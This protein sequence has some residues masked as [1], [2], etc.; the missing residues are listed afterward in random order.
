MAM[1]AALT[2]RLAARAT[3][4][5]P[6]IT[7]IWEATTVVVSSLYVGLYAWPASVAP[8]RWVWGSHGDA[9]GNAFLFTWV[10]QAVLTGH[11]NSIDTQV[12]IPFG[13]NL[14]ALP[15]EPAF[16]WA[17][18]LLAAAFGAVASLNLISFL[19]IPL[20]AWA[21][22]RLCIYLTGSPLAAFFAGVAYGCSTF[23]LSNTRGEP[24][25][26]QVWIFPLAA[27]ALLKVMAAPGKGT[28]VAAAIAVAASAVVN[29]Y[30]TLFAALMC[31]VLVLAWNGAATIQTR[32]VTLLP[33]A[34]SA[35]A[36]FLGVVLTGLLYAG[37]LADLQQR[38]QATLRSTSQLADLAPGYLDFVLPSQ[39]NPWFGGLATARFL[40]SEAS[41]GHFGLSQMV[42]PAA[43][44]VLAPFGI[45]LLFRGVFRSQSDS[46]TTN[47]N[48]NLVALFCVGLL[49]LW[50]TVPPTA[51]PHA[52]RV[53]SLQL[54]VHHFFPQFQHFSRATILL[55]LGL[56][57]LA[58][59][60]LAWMA[61][62]WAV[63]AIP[64]ALLL[65]ASVLV[66]GYE[67][68]PDSA[69]EVVPPPAD[70]WVASHPGTYAVAD[71]PLIP[72]G[73]GGNEYTYLFEQR[74]HGHPL[75]NG[76]L[77][78][79]EAESMREEFRDPN[80]ADVPGHLA[81]LGVR[82][83]LWH[84]DV[85][86]SYNRLSTSLAAPYYAWV[87][88]SPGYQLEAA[89]P[90]GSA[91]YSITAATNEPFA[92]YAAGFDPIRPAP[93]GRPARPMPASSN[94]GLID[95]Y[96]SGSPAIIDLSFDC[97]G[98]GGG[99]ALRFAGKELGSSELIPG[100]PATIAV[101]VSI[102]SGLTQLELARTSVPANADATAL[103]TLVTTSPT[104][105]S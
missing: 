43:V 33:L 90:D 24:T 94:P 83:V 81:A 87:P 17:Q 54:D 71:Y 79:T 50:L 93:D 30:F 42:T 53:L 74:F 29:F 41:T 56:V 66:E 39:W 80:R 15:H 89:F 55:D 18:L 98:Q 52:L 99:V 27:W 25:L 46:E 67:I 73:S 70:A 45:V 1:R 85:L 91:V 12:A 51:F 5:D 11:S 8:A 58:A 26:A 88:H 20:T 57:P 40:A 100:R 2:R 7:R 84:P 22:Y 28:V 95:V 96:D 48:L 104:A 103:C 72:A 65:A 61:R 13:E 36:G 14:L 64:L 63:A 69:L 35:L 34:A 21:M 102:A 19:A 32:R 105:G 9:L 97:F 23:L 78:G 76:Q 62:R 60:A 92:F 101:R 82:Y 49:G 86:E 68:V 47:R 4:N 16:Y 37:N 59:A 6:L 3:A 44:L 31:T 10:D 75:L 38:A 77:A